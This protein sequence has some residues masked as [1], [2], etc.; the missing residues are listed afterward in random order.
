[1][2]ISNNKEEIEKI[3]NYDIIGAAEIQKSAK[4]AGAGLLREAQAQAYAA[5]KFL[6]KN[7]KK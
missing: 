5:R 1:M 3:A 7:K 4:L 2:K 6:K